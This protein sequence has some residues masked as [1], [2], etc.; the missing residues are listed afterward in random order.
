MHVPQSHIRPPN[1]ISTFHKAIEPNTCFTAGYLYHTGTAVYIVQLYSSTYI[2]RSVNA[3]GQ[4]LF[5]ELSF[6]QPAQIM[7]GTVR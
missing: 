6:E 4:F 7:Y 3:D 1:T 2:Y 5:S